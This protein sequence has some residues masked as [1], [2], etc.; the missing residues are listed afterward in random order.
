M[1]IDIVTSWEERGGSVEDTKGEERVLC[2]KEA[3]HLIL[4]LVSSCGVVGI[5][6]L[7]D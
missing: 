1:G 6:L 2:R 3:V 4:A 5:G 7:S